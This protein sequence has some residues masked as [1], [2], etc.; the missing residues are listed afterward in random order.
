M[1]KYDK[2][3]L[4][5]LKGKS[6]ANIPFDD[7]CQLLRRLGFEERIRGGHHTFRK[8]GVEEKPNLQRNGSK[9]KA[10]Q[11]RQVR[12]IILKYKLKLGDDN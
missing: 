5:I 10:Y 7:L 6:D 12:E 11:V 4:R 2:L 1:G 3:L 9:A 8:E